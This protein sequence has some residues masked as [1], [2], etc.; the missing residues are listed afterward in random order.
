[1]ILVRRISFL[2]VV[3]ILAGCGL[4][5]DPLSERDCEC[6][7]V[8]Q[9]AAQLPITPDGDTLGIDNVDTGEGADGFAVGG[10]RDEPAGFD[11][12]LIEETMAA[13]GFNMRV[14]VDEENSWNAIFFPGASRAQSQWTIDFTQTEGQVGFRVSVAVDGT[15]WG[16]ETIEDLWDSYQEDYDSA[17]QA[18]VERQQEAIAELQ[19]L[20]A[21]MQTMLADQ[22]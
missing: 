22:P 8:D 20:E 19:D 11:R 2:I 15:P 7:L 3:L 18:Q 13:A 9:W 17:L 6:E 4:F 14:D 21:V 12:Q 16:L 5:A 1:M 10:S